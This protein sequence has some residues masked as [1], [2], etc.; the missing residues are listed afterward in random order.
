M[1]GKLMSF[2]RKGSRVERLAD[3]LLSSIGVCTPVRHEDDLGVDFHCQLGSVQEGGY[4]TYHS[5]FILQVKSNLDHGILYG[6]RNPEKWV[7]ESTAW[8]FQNKIPFFVGTVDLDKS[9]IS[10][11]DTTGLW[12]VYNRSGAWSSQIRLVSKPHTEGE[13]RENVDSVPLENWIDGCG[14]GFRHT[15]DLGNPLICFS[16]SDLQ[17]RGRMDLSMANFT[18]WIYFEQKNI[19]NRDLGLRTFL[20]VKGNEPGSH[21]VRT[22]MSFEAHQHLQPEHVVGELYPGLVS[23]LIKLK[24]QGREKEWRALK[25]FLRYSPPSRLDASLYR[26]DSELFDWLKP[27]D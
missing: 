21:I 2:A 8:L 14:D 4:V 15:V 24:E 1:S 17:S 16:I 19:V 13:M 3:F 7:S 26:A 22:G 20:E 12:Q 25:E 5:P 23:I 9:A 11:Y 27:S 6:E 18:N 10:I